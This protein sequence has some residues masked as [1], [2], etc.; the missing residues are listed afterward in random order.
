MKN[1]EII[2][3]LL[4][5]D[6]EMDMDCIIKPSKSEQE[7]LRTMDGYPFADTKHADCALV[8]DNHDLVKVIVDCSGSMWD[9]TENVLSAIIDIARKNKA[10]SIHA[11]T[12]NE[13]K[14]IGTYTE[15][16]IDIDRVKMRIEDFQESHLA[17]VLFSQ[18]VIGFTDKHIKPEQTYIITDTELYSE[19]V[20]WQKETWVKHATFYLVDANESSKIDVFGTVFTLSD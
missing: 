19:F 6:L 5:H 8:K 18:N 7:I 17:T 14:Y 10:V 4:N 2:M 13:N 11:I 9:Y 3:T 1:K 20:D 15:K 16:S 12:E